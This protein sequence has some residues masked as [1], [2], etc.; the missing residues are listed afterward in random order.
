MARRAWRQYPS[1]F[2]NKPGVSISAS[3]RLVSEAIRTNCKYGKML[4]HNLK[5]ADI[6]AECGYERCEK[7]TF[8][9]DRDLAVRPVNTRVQ[10]NS[11]FFALKHI[12]QTDAESAWTVDQFD[13]LGK[14]CEEEAKDDSIDW[15]CDRAETTVV[16]MPSALLLD[17]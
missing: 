13:D 3:Q 6:L 2:Q 16:M 9:S 5:L 8:S 11:S 4:D 10:I 15:R 14:K 1:S 17:I 7:D 12:A